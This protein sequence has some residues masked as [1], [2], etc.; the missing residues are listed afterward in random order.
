MIEERRFSGGLSLAFS[1]WLVALVCLVFVIQGGA[2]YTH[3]ATAFPAL[4]SFR[5]AIMPWF[6][7][8]YVF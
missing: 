1:I 4:A 6:S 8:P 7:R 3:V 2:L 5:E